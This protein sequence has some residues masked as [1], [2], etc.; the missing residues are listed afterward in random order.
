[1]VKKVGLRPHVMKVAEPESEPGGPALVAGFSTAVP[2]WVMCLYQPGGAGQVAFLFRASVS[3]SGNLE[4]RI[5]LST[6]DR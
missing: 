1:M 3:L 6:L 4:G 2:G 5:G